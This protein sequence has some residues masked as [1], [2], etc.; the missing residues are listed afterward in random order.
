L[1]KLYLILD[2]NSGP[3]DDWARGAAGIQHSYTLEL[4]PG[5]TGVDSNYGFTLPEDR[6][7]KVITKIENN[8]DIFYLLFKFLFKGRYRDIQW[9]KSFY[10]FISLNF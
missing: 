9:H 3:S 1:V 6:V 7:P 4:A 8:K 10:S 5:Q 2:I